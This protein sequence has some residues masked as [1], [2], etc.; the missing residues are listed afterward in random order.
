[1]FTL[2]L[3]SSSVLVTGRPI[4]AMTCGLLFTPKTATWYVYRR[5]RVSTRSISTLS[6]HE[7]KLHHVSLY[8]VDV[9]V[10]NPYTN[11]AHVR[12]T[13]F[14]YNSFSATAVSKTAGAATRS[15]LSPHCLQTVSL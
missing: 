4:G 13:G 11:A 8:V 3:S 5:L 2:C 1:V 14:S 9:R 12:V 6:F 7:Q 10:F 15:S